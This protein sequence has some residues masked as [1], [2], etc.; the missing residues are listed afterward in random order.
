MSCHCTFQATT[1]G[2]EI[3]KFKLKLKC[4]GNFE[5]LALSDRVNLFFAK[6]L[7]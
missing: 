5:L 6:R 2:M 3:S 1:L 4:L 7:I